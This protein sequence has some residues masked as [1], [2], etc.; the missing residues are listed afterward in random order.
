MKRALSVIASL[1][2]L[3]CAHASPDGH[4]VLDPP[5]HNLR[6]QTAKDDLPES[7]CDP[8]KDGAGNLVYKCVT[9][10]YSDYKA[11]LDKIDQLQTELKNCQA[12]KP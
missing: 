2:L 3:S 11:Q 12:S 1:L 9:F 8:E 7:K 4:F 6:G 10:F 5:N